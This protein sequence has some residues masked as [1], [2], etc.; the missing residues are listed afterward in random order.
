[1]E[2]VGADLAGLARKETSSPPDVLAQLTGSKIKR[3]RQSKAMVDS[4]R[5]D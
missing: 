5:G 2:L 3:M 4:E 1:M